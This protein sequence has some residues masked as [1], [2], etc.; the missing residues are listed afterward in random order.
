MSQDT[1]AR[2][3]LDELIAAGEHG[4][5]AADLADLWRRGRSPALAGFAVDRFR[6]I[7][8]AAGLP[9]TRVFVLRSFTVEPVL[10]LLEAEAAAAGIDLRAQAGDFNAYIQET[11][12][13]D[14]RLYAFDPHVVI[15]AV[16]TRDIAP[17]LW[18]GFADLAPADA[19]SVA[20]RVEAALRN[21]VRAFR[22]RSKAHLVVHLLE[23]PAAPAAGI[24]DA[25]V[26]SGQVA[27]IRALNERIRRVAREVQGVYVLDYDALVARH[28]RTAWHDERKWQS[29]RLP[30]SAYGLVHLAEEWLRF[31]QPLTGK[32]CKVLVTDLDNT[33][34][35]GV[36][37]EDGMEGIRIDREYPGAA[38]RNVQRVILDLHR[39][40][41]VLAVC[42]KNNPA[43]ARE[44]LE[45]HPEMLLRPEHFASL[46][47]NWVDKA[48]NLREIAAELNLGLDAFA[49]LDDSKVEREWVRRELPQVTVID[50]PD[51]P[52]LY[53][54]T[55]RA[56]PVFERLVVSEED[57]NRGQYYAS[58]RQR[59][60]L[61]DRAGSL[62]DF[63]RSLGMKLVLGPVGP[64][65]LTRV[66]QLTQ[67]TNQFNLT[68]RRYSEQQIA[69]MADEPRWRVYWARATDRFGDNGIIAVAIVRLDED[70]WDIDTFL[71]SCRVIG[72]TVETSILAHLAQIAAESGASRLRGTY[73][74]TKKNGQVVDFYPSHGFRCIEASDA[75]IRWELDLARGGISQP[76]WIDSTVL[77]ERETV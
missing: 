3:R 52:A 73:L 34:W 70:A 18:E 69:A 59:E 33:L 12:S 51:D 13:P 20:D 39:R 41:I 72:R 50:L 16:Q 74:P 60:E 65:T 22:A 4:A 11:M 6:R 62:E 40:G 71:M 53:A 31:V 44:A 14:S 15:L 47:I 32:I 27:A 45:R 19:T 54:H 66:A 35:G 64:D 68:T 76:A 5:A 1:D 67:K 10:P 37:G 46:R 43:D 28:G 23:T 36:I 38:Y 63:Y 17:E 49:F 58:E 42:S 57:R 29:F 25:Q 77:C 8:S 56:C 21:C 61:R 30:L 9:A 24:L 75:G 26:E 2:Q 7:A 55:L 48:T